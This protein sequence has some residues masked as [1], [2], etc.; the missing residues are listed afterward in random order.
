[1]DWVFRYTK[2]HLEKTSSRAGENAGKKRILKYINFSNNL[3]YTEKSK[4]VSYR[5]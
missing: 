5:Q 2:Y 3:S 4:Y 1:M